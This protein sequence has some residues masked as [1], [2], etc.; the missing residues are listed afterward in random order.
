MDKWSDV[1]NA[2]YFTD[3]FRWDI[4]AYSYFESYVFYTF[5]VKHFGLSLFLNALWK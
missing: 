5:I 4:F 1:A 2:G 3:N